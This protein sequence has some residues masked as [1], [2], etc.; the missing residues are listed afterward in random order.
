[1]SSQKGRAAKVRSFA[2]QFGKKGEFVIEETGKKGK[3]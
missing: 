3:K 1:V 2:E